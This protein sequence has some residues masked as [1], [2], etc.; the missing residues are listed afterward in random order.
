MHLIHCETSFSVVVVVIGFYL[1]FL[2]FVSKEQ[3]YYLSENNVTSEV[4]ENGFRKS[5][6]PTFGQISQRLY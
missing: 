2:S 4:F 5:C 3:A 6:C 1:F